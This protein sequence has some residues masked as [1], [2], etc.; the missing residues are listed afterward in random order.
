[1]S[2]TTPCP[3]V[4]IYLC[5][6][7]DYLCVCVDMRVCVYVCV[8]MS[9]T[10]MSDRTARSMS[11]TAASPPHCCSYTY[12]CMCFCVCV[13]ARARVYVCLQTCTSYRAALGTS[14][15]HTHTLHTYI[16]AHLSCRTSQ[17]TP[18]TPS[19]SPNRSNFVLPPRLPPRPQ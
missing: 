5:V 19:C 6:C 17:S 9:K 8:C 15:T 16:H 12:P 10:Y 18:H 4:P 11:H 2:H 3:P 13:C 7:V 1:M 14:L